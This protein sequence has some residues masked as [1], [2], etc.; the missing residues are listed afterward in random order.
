MKKK[1][2][3]LI[4]LLVVIVIVGILASLILPGLS[5][6][7]AAAR[8]T[9]DASNL[10]QL[11]LAWLRAQDVNGEAMMP[12]M[13]LDVTN[14]PKYPRY[15]FGA[16]DNSQTPPAVVFKD[17]FWPPSWNPTSGC[18]KTPISVPTT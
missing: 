14:E 18:F 4:E 3:T 12:W 17:G 13:T 2:F 9:Q 15:W 5:A 16:I 11:T 8:T 7:R 6:A 1:G 10:R